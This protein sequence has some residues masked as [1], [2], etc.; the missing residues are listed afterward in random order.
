MTKPV[1]AYIR[2]AERTLDSARL[3][4]DSADTEGACNRAYYAM[5]YAA[6]AAL[7]A[8]GAEAPGAVIKTHTGLI[9][10]FGQKLVV[11][12]RVG[13]EQGRALS[14]IHTM[15]LLADYTDEPPG[16]DDASNAFALARAFVAAMRSIVTKADS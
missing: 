13:V 4:L 1:T 14:Q 11:T 9:S 7:W 16:A 15:R 6:H 2:K 12:K 8:T 10:T 3:L 5:F